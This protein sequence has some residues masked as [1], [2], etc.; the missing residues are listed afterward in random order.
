LRQ[1]LRL[2]ENDHAVL[3]SFHHIIFD[4][5]SVGVLVRLC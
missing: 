2:G 3:F 1:A 5:W 4:G